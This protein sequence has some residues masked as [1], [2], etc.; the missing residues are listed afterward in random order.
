L[1]IPSTAPDASD[2]RGS[3]G[4]ISVLILCSDRFDDLIR[5]LSSLE[6]LGD[7]LLEV[8]VLQNAPSIEWEKD[9]L[10]AL[11]AAVRDKCFILP[12]E[13]RLNCLQGRN[14]LVE[15]ARGDIVFILD[16]DAYLL[17]SAGI[18]RGVEILQ[19]DSR[20]G[21]IAFPQC[22][23][24]GEIIKEFMQPAPVN[25]PCLT[26]GFTGFAALV[27][28]DVYRKLGG[29]Q[30]ILVAFKE[31][32]E[33]CRRQLELGYSVCYLPTP[34]VC[35][36]PSQI[37]R[38]AWYRAKMDTRN[39]WYVAVLHE[40]LWYLWFSLPR[41]IWSGRSYLKETD[42]WPDSPRRPLFREA[43]QEF[44]RDLPEL[45]KRRKPLKLSTLRTWQRIKKSYPPYP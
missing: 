6:I 26:C 2:S 23:A 1:N 32:N 41:R 11:P 27:R 4:K 9:R 38:N 31:E 14:R 33:F 8:R 44:F 36:A 22:D 39:G 16:D 13:K 12:S 7:L 24:K 15:E 42:S 10:D 45:I 18:Q 19:R 25:Y 21:S 29:F 28:T 20:I 17:E 43:L 40:P 5:G 34:T 35:H 37:G 30:E 3:T